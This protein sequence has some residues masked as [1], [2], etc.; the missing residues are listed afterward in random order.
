MDWQNR[1]TRIVSATA[2][3]TTAL[4][5]GWVASARDAFAHPRL[6]QARDQLLSLLQDRA[7]RDALL[8]TCAEL[9]TLHAE[10]SAAPTPTVEQL[11]QLSTLSELSLALS[12]QA[13]EQELSDSDRFVHAV[14]QLPPLF[15]RAVACGLLPGSAQL[16]QFD[17]KVAAVQ[18]AAQSALRPPLFRKG[19]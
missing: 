16:A 7:E 11:N 1:L 5:G 14:T 19:P 4:Q 13:I 3:V 8:Q 10:L 17:Q 12:T 15:R 6:A 2:P 9:N 18:S